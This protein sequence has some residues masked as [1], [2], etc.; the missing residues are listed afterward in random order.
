[1]DERAPYRYDT[2][3]PLEDWLQHVEGVA[4]RAVPLPTELAGLIA[5]V[6]EALV[7]LADDSP[8][9]ALRAIGAVERI[10][11]AVARTAAHDVTA[12]NPSPKARSTALGLP[13]GDADSRIFHYLHRR[14]V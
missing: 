13:V 9:A 3:G 14:S 12:D 7:K 4:A 2:A 10:T 11:D 6:E 5:N 1:M 8:L